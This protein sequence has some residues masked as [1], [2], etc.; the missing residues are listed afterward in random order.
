MTL[1]LT[2]LLVAVSAGGFAQFSGLSS[3]GDGASL[4]FVS[5][6]RLRGTAEPRNAKVFVAGAEGVSL[7]RAREAE[8]VPANSPACTVGGFADYVNAE[9]A[10]NGAVA[11]IYT[12]NTNSMCSYPPFLYRTEV[13]GLSLPG[14][15]RIG[16]NG[17]YG[18]NFDDLT[19]RLTNVTIS[20]GDMRTNGLIPVNL[21]MPPFPEY[22]QMPYNGLRAIADDGTAIVGITDGFST[23]RG[24]LLRPGAEPVAFTQ[25]LPLGID[26]AAAH[27]LMRRQDGLYLFDMAGGQATLLLPSTAPAFNFRMSDDARRVLYLGEGQVHVLDTATLADRTLTSDQWKIAD[28]TLSG[29]GK[30]AYAVTGQGRLL[31]IDVDSGASAELIGH[32]PYLSAQVPSLT[33]GLIATLNGVGLSDTVLDGAPPFQA[34]LGNLTMWIGERKVPVIHLEPNSVSF[35]VPWDIQAE[36]GK[37]RIQAEV[38][39]EHTPFYFPEAIVGLAAESIPRAGLVTRL[40]WEPFYVG[41][42]SP[43]EIVHVFAL[44]FGPV[45]P[46]VPEGE[47]APAAEPY[48]RLALPLACDNLDVLYAGLAPYSVQRVYQLDLRI[49]PKVGYQQ[50][51]C[52]LGDRAPFIFL[53]LNVAP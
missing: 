22:I 33:P 17:R 37:I 19:S 8:D 9:T 7:F 29:D 36:N 45:S 51:R 27:I 30:V 42:V 2:L 44:G 24:F 20:Y 52:T 21:S 10:S 16:P 28:A 41:P 48:A 14:I 18:I 26:A 46:E 31:K 6:L 49:G 11:L 1:R 32:T 34:W 25:G 3:T 43:G 12:A 39:G 15:T 50:F 5:T 47:L 53:T 40:N 35:L 23:R 38:P 13:G 4:Y